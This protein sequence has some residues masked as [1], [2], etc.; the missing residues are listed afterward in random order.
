M[1]TP[2]KSKID[3][4]LVLIIVL[5][6]GLSTLPMFFLGSVSW[7][8][9]IVLSGVTIFIIYV[10]ATTC[11]EI[12]DNMLY[13]RTGWLKPIEINISSIVKISETNNILS[14]PV[15]S[16]DRLEIEYNKRKKNYDF[17]KNENRFSIQNK[18][19]KPSG[20]H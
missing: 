15:T 16:L 18:R 11:Y 4:G 19:I 17:S 10:F 1:K 2:Y 12:E 9:L 8:G 3:I 20:Y 7:L 14:A 5:I 13:I 6:M